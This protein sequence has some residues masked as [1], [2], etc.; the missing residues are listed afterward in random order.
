MK[1]RA[2]EKICAENAVVRAAALRRLTDRELL[3]DAAQNAAD[4]EARLLAARRLEVF[5]KP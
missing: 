3:A 5:S 4:A 2:V 1:A